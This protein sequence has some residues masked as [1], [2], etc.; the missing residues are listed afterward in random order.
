M[1]KVKDCNHEYWS[2]IERFYAEAPKIT[3]ISVD[4]ADLLLYNV[5]TIAYMCL[6]CGHTWSKR[7]LGSSTRSAPSLEPPIQFHAYLSLQHEEWV[8]AYL[9]GKSLWIIDKDTLNK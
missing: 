8:S 4:N 2:E 1:S 5:T 6:S 7:F 3:N 9:E